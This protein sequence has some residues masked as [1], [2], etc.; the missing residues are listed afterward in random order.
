[1]NKYIKDGKVGVL[2]SPGF[3]SGWSTWN[4]D[5]SEYLLFDRELIQA[6]LDGDFNKVESIAEA[7]IGEETYLHTGG[8]HDLTVHWLDPGTQF[9]VDEYDGHETL[10]VLEEVDLFTA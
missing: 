5:Y 8:A 3:G 1:M 6:V 10:K 9:K 4:P 2:I 7:T